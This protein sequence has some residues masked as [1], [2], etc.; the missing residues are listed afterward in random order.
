MKENHIIDLQIAKNDLSTQLSSLTEE[1]SKKTEKINLLKSSIEN[2]K[3]E[4][5][6]LQEQKDKVGL[7]KNKEV[8][9][10]INQLKV[11]K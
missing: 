4:L 7:I 8:E 9:E 2:I 6:E 5:K 10:L 1:S 11:L 3:I